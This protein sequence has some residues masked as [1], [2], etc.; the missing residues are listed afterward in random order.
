M[1]R[2]GGGARGYVSEIHIFQIHAL[3]QPF[4]KSLSLPHSIAWFVETGCGKT[5]MDIVPSKALSLSPSLSFAGTPHVGRYNVCLTP[6]PRPSCG[7]WLHNDV[8]RELNN[9]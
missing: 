3:G 1:G 9:C 6:E 7:H 8:L 2:A 4:I 5:L